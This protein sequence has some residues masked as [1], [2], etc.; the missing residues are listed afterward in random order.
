MISYN[1]FAEAVQAHQAGQLHQAL[2]L[3]LQIAKEDSS[4]HQLHQCLA[5]VYSDLD[6]RSQASYHFLKALALQADNPAYHY[7][8]AHFLTADKDYHLA[9]KHLQQAKQ[10]KP[11]YHKATL[12]QI[13]LYAELGDSK[14]M[15]QALEQIDPFDSSLTVSE[16]L[17]LCQKFMRYKVNTKLSAFYQKLQQS[18]TDDVLDLLRLKALAQFCADPKMSHGP[19]LLPAVLETL[20]S[21][22]FLSLPKS[23]LLLHAPTELVY[24]AFKTWQQSVSLAP[25]VV[26]RSYVRGIEDKLATSTLKIGFLAQDWFNLS[27][28]ELLQPLVIQLQQQGF[29]VV[30]FLLEPANLEHRLRDFYQEHTKIVYCGAMGHEAIAHRIYLE[31]ISVLIR[32]KDFR[33]FAAEKV[34][35]LRPAPIQIDYLSTIPAAADYID[36][37]IVDEQ[38]IP[39]KDVAFFAKTKLLYA[40]GCYHPRYQVGQFD[41]QWQLGSTSAVQ[42]AKLPYKIRFGCFNMAMKLCDTYLACVGNILQKVP[43]SCLVLLDENPL[44]TAH[45]TKILKQYVKPKRLIFVPRTEPVEHLARLSQV[46]LN[47]DTFLCSGHTT[48][49]D[50]FYVQTPVL[51]LAGQTMHARVTT[52]M[53]HELSLPELIAHSTTEYIAKA[54]QYATCQDF[55]GAIQAKLQRHC[56]DFFA[57]EGQAL[58][59]AQQCQ[60]LAGQQPI[61]TPLNTASCSIIMPFYRKY[62][63]FVAVFGAYNRAAFEAYRG[64]LELIIVLDSPDESE[65]LHD[66]LTT[67][68]AQEPTGFNITTLVEHQEHAWRPPCIAINKGVAAAAYDYVL[69]LSPESIITPA[70]LEQLLGHASSKQFT[71]GLVHFADYEELET[72]LTTAPEELAWSNYGSICAPKAALKTLGGYDESLDK[73][74]GDDDDIRLRLKQFGLTHAIVRAL[75]THVQFP[76]RSENAFCATTT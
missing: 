36:H 46:S 47:L 73:W 41:W 7:N 58:W 30:L 10:L 19:E 35:A 32:L 50:S 6:Q 63:E 65:L 2:D 17:D 31:A 3:Y 43:N 62:H 74:G 51:T 13:H 61:D 67:L 33:H 22:S 23:Y 66:Y 15:H 45:L 55:A 71:T 37:H 69:V 4:N 14:S 39:S 53:L 70:G 56:Q 60:K 29:E 9:L 48:S 16:K 21:H 44:T 5:L 34:L 38:S 72:V 76:K 25:D 64:Q 68:Q 54:V 8:Y 1:T 59:V 49:V 75:V 12:E 57:S 24:F 18:R 40:P 28:A 11:D 26:Q 20:H 52:A 27:T 42:L